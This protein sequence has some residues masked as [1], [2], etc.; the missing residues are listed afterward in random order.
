MSGQ[1]IATSHEL[2]TP[3]AGFVREIPF[4][5]GKSRLLP[6]NLSVSQANQWARYVTSILH[7]KVAEPPMGHP[8]V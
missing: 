5:S 2:F 3:N 1:I 8:H 4:V 7:L 6:G